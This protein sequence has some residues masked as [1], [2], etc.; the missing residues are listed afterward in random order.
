MSDNVV[1]LPCLTRCDLKA[2]EMLR[3]IADNNPKHAFVIVWPE[4]ES[5]P[6]YHCS[7]SDMAVV[8]L[9]MQGFIHKFYNGDLGDRHF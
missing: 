7:T 8:L 4:D 2:P 5:A 1:K 6:N 3:D 9:R